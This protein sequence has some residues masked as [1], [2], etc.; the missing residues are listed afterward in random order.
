MKQAI[1][2]T[3]AGLFCLGLAAQRPG[4]VRRGGRVPGGVATSVREA[5]DGS[6]VGRRECA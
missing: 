1:V 5:W 3:A 2:F 4:V 6:P